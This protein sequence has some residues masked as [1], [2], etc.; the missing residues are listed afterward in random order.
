MNTGAVV[1]WGHQSDSPAPLKAILI[2]EA[3]CDGGLDQGVSN[4]DGKN[5]LVS[6]YVLK[7]ELRGFADGIVC[8]CET[9]SPG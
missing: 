7:V 2:I 8:R 1:H 5:S 9:E 4:G 3:R 6:G